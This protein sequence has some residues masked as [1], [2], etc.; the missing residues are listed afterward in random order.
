MELKNI[1]KIKPGMRAWNTELSEWGTIVSVDGGEVEMDY[2][3]D[4]YNEDNVEDIC[5][6]LPVAEGKRLA[7][8]TEA[9]ICWETD[10][11]CE[12]PFYC[13]DYDENV[14]ELEVTEG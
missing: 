9:L 10:A 5:N 12:Y 13:P 7:R 4:E 1:E 2:D 14:Y 6:I 8:D 3:D 11:D